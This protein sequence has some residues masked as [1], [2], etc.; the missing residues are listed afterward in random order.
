MFQLLQGVL[1]KVFPSLIRRR[2]NHFH[3]LPCGI[4]MIIG[5]NGFIWIS[6][7]TQDHENNINNEDANAVRNPNLQVFFNINKILLYRYKIF[8]QFLGN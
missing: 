2:R 7:T 8:Y 5:N 1:V 6:P 4:S 3:V